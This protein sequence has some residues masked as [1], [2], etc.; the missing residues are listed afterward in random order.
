M[1]KFVTIFFIQKLVTSIILL[2]I[3]SLFLNINRVEYN[4]K[5]TLDYSSFYTKKYFYFT[6]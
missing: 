3:V 6:Y 4:N 1:A 2:L 5:A